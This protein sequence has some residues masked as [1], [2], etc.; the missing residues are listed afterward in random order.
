MLRLYLDLCCFNRPFDDQSQLK[1]KLETEAKLAIQERIL[2]GVYELA[3]SYIMDF[4]NAQNPF[5]VKMSSI[6]DWKVFACACASENDNVIYFAESLASKGIKSC[7]ALH[8]SCAVE[9]LCDYFVTTDR[10]L[11]NTPVEGITIIS[12]TRFIEDQD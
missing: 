9:M 7:D 10:K 4:E 2:D 3:W 8:I 11:L 5:P 6:A 1:V 12:P